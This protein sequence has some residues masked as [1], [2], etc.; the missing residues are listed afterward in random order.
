MTRMLLSITLCLA[1]AAVMA[2]AAPSK[3]TPVDSELKEVERIM[4]PPGTH[5]DYRQ[6]RN[7]MQ[8]RNAQKM[9]RIVGEGS[10]EMPD[11]HKKAQMEA[12][13]APSDR[14][15]WSG[16]P[17]EL[18]KDMAIYS[19][20]AYCR[21]LQ[22]LASWTCAPLCS[23]PRVTGTRYVNVFV[24]DPT[25]TKGYAAV[26]DA[27]QAIIISFR[28]SQNIQNWFNNLDFIRRSY[29]AA[30]PAVYQST[31]SQ[32]SIH[33]GFWNTYNPVRQALSQTLSQLVGQYPSY[34]VIFTGH[35]L[36][37][38]VAE[39]AA[40]EMTVT[41]NL[42]TSQVKLI[43][44]GA[45]R[46]GNSQYSGLLTAL[47]I[48]IDRVVNENDIVPHALGEWLGFEQTIGEKYIHGGQV[49]V[50]EGEEDSEC[51]DSRVPFLSI[52]AHLQAFGV[53]FKTGCTDD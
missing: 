9:H 26:N 5:F 41:L 44:L 24:N 52:S 28:G 15:V 27:K 32:I 34:T 38:A 21:N 7:D 8:D 2:M 17:L 47:G 16:A 1:L 35:S 39:L 33:S 30:V 4:S 19:S 13:D 20:I 42:P 14:A 43:T 37:A 53:P 12:S 11:A 45:P 48:E 51:S 31:A 25:E 29:P 50:C 46:V 3:T 49:Y 40:A 22:S 6:F 36:G 18:A 10:T 23:D